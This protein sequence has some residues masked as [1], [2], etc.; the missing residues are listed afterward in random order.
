MGIWVYG[1]INSTDKQNHPTSNVRYS[2]NNTALN[3][4]ALRIKIVTN[5]LACVG[6]TIHTPA[7][8]VLVLATI[9]PN[10]KFCGTSHTHR[11]ITL[12]HIVLNVIYVCN[13]QSIVRK[14]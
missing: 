11:T 2:I 8:F 5:V 4:D 13:L 9:A 1:I 12:Y 14:R 7:R 10:D 3:D 6:R